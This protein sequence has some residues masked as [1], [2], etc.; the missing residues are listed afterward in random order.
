MALA[1]TAL[2]WFFGAN[3]LKM[4]LYDFSSG[5]C[6]NGLQA[7]GVSLNQ[8]AESTLC[9]LRAISLMSDIGNQALI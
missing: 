5:G 2:D 1:R 8:G 9:C 7:N 4:R 3:D 6:S